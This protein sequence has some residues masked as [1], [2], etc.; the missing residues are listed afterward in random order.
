MKKRLTD[1]LR[2][3]ASYVDEFAKATY[4]MRKTANALSCEERAHFFEEAAGEFERAAA[5]LVGDLF[6]AMQ[7][8]PSNEMAQAAFKRGLQA[9][10]QRENAE[11]L[12]QECKNSTEY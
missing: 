3:F 2:L 9:A 1:E 5:R 10:L 7:D 4:D 6:G 12:E 8:L 11:D